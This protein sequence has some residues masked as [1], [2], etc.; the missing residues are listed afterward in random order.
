MPLMN[1]CPR[2]E[3]LPFFN[4][5]ESANNIRVCHKPQGEGQTRP[6]RGQTRYPFGRSV[7][8]DTESHIHTGLES[9]SGYSKIPKRIKDKI[10]TSLLQGSG[11][12][13]LLFK[14]P[15]YSLKLIQLPGQTCTSKVSVGSMSTGPD[16]QNET[17][18]E[19]IGSVE[20]TPI[21]I[22]RSIRENSAK[23]C[24]TRCLVCHLV[25]HLCSSTT[26]PAG[27]R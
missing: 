21:R 8:A 12:M 25:D 7:L 6:F 13:Y 27:N 16:L 26:S 11:G 17:E 14:I 22:V 5:L 18:Q 2:D 15:L 20:N 9:G 4:R 24:P 23:Y 19:D 3:F 1:P 10:M